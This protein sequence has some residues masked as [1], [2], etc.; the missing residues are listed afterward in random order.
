[1][2]WPAADR[3]VVDAGP[4]GPWTG[5]PGLSV[6]VCIGDLTGRR[7]GREFRRE[8]ATRQAI[9]EAD[10]VRI[11]HLRCGGGSV[12]PGCICAAGRTSIGEGNKERFEVRLEVGDPGRRVGR[13]RIPIHADR[14]F[15]CAASHIFYRRSGA[16]RNREKHSWRLE[17][18]IPYL[19]PV[20]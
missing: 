18:F 1:M 10:G 3:L 2:V 4:E 6:I 15:P 19:W 7:R 17:V 11:N 5:Y 14:W 13:G 20:I 12:D 16:R 9:R 8:G